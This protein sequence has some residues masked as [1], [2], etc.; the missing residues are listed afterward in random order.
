M[1]GA[2]VRQWVTRHETTEESRC[3]L[4]PDKPLEGSVAALSG[5]RQPRSLLVPAVSEEPPVSV[6]RGGGT[7]AGRAP[8]WEGAWALWEELRDSGPGSAGKTE[9]KGGRAEAGREL[10]QAGSSSQT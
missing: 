4:V 1:V 7:C 8:V 2:L 3:L 10:W 9:S 6:G 5:R